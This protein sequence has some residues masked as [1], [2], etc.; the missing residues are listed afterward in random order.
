MLATTSEW[1]IT[2]DENLNIIERFTKS[3]MRLFDPP[4]SDVKFC[5]HRLFNNHYND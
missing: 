4:Y 1:R 2:V 3:G 5:S